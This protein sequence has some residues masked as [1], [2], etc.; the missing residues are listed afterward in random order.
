MT[1]VPH[2]TQTRQAL[3]RQ[4]RQLQQPLQQGP[5]QGGQCQHHA[6][7]KRMDGFGDRSTQL[8]PEQTHPDDQSQARHQRRDGRNPEFICRVQ[9]PET[10]ADQAGQQGHGS[11]HLQLRD[12]NPMQFRRQSRSYKRDQRICRQHQNR[13]HREQQGTHRGVE[14]RE[15]VGSLVAGATA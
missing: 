5:H 1:P 6:T 2:Q 7:P 10:K 14:R 3:S 9:G 8:P 15:D 11:H 13:R 12:G 4:R